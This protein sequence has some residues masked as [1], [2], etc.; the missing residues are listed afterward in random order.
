[1]NQ[2]SFKD[3]LLRLFKWTKLCEEPKIKLIFLLIVVA[4]PNKTTFWTR[5]LSDIEQKLKD[6]KIIPHRIDLDLSEKCLRMFL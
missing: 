3:I 2:N 6:I 1:M 5:F 4:E